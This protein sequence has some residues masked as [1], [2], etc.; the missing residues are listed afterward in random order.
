MTKKDYV[1]IAKIL[2]EASVFCHP[3]HIGSI[4]AMFCSVLKDDN[5]RFD[6]T[7]FIKACGKEN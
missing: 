3:E 6:S 5:P 4:V 2:N 7:R 1:K